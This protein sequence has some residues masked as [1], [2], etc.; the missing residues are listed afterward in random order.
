MPKGKVLIVDN[1]PDF[2]RLLAEIIGEQ[3]AM[4]IR[5][6]AAYWPLRLWLRKKIDLAIVDVHMP[7]M[8]GFA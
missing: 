3:A 7:E 8:N 6:T 5:R 4:C 1:S 2:L